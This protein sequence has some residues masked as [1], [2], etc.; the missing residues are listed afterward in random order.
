MQLYS[1]LVR[2]TQYLELS[3]P[4]VVSSSILREW[5]K[6]DLLDLKSVISNNAISIREDGKMVGKVA[7][8]YILNFCNTG[9]QISRIPTNANPS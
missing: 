5:Q 6:F 4:S 8:F 3:L 7:G 1:E 9:R 2:T